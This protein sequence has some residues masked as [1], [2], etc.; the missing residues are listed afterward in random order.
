LDF[1][2]IDK[3]FINFN[4]EQLILDCSTLQAKGEYK[5]FNYIKIS[6][7]IPK[8]IF[9]YVSFSSSS[10]SSSNFNCNIN[11]NNNNLNNKNKGKKNKNKNKEKDIEINLKY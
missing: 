6:N 7:N 3:L 5:Y 9:D 4:N 2:F 8:Y 11:G 1:T 10:S